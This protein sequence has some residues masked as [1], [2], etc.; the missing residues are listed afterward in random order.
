MKMI[1]KT[2]A[3]DFRNTTNE[4][5]KTLLS[6]K[7]AFLIKKHANS[8]KMKLLKVNKHLNFINIKVK[9]KILY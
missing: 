4:S 2:A 7:N 8:I 6:E 5:I 9:L 3:V 1:N